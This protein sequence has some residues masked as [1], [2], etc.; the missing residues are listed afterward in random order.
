ML[1]YVVLYVH[2][3]SLSTDALKVVKVKLAPWG[4]SSLAYSLAS[5]VSV[6][7]QVTGLGLGECRV[8]P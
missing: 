7:L 3:Q 4:F 5:P 8:E 2:W 1:Q 6:V